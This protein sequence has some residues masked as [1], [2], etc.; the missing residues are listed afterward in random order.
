MKGDLT[1][2]PITKTM[3]LFA[4]PMILGNMLQQTYNVADTLIVG[5]FLGSDALAAVGS[6]YT[7]MSFLTSILL[8][9]CMGSGAVFSIAFGE[10]NEEKL[11]NSMYVSLILIGAVAIVLNVLVFVFLDP[12]MGLL[13]VPGRVYPM[14]KEYLWIIFFGIMATFLY[15]YFASLL[16]SLGNSVVPL[17]FL[18]VCAILNIFLDLAFVLWIKMGVGGAALATVISQYIS[19]IGI[20]IYTYV[21]MPQFRFEKKYCK[22]SRG[23]AKEITQFSFLTSLQQ[24]VM[25]FGILMVQG[26]INSFG[27]VVMAAFAAGVKIDSFAYMPVQDFGNAFSVFVAQNHGAKKEERI[28][29]GIKK[30]VGIAVVFCLIISAGVFLFAGPL[31]TIFVRA[32]ETEVIRIGAQYLRVEGAFYFGIGCLFLLYG[33]YRAVEKPGMS[34]VLTVISLGTR[35]I[36]AYT[37][38]SIEAIGVMGIWWSVPIGWILADLTGWIYYKLHKKELF[39]KS[40]M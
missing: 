33:F 31:M 2:G 29:L 28:R 11:K 20:A 27:P 4:L 1:K 35:V 6:S 37:L 23:I 24:S 39:Q 21:K 12:I 14:M 10:R 19:G 16:R 15:N 7:L 3:L 26:L 32:E 9:L 18:A 36:L 25:N 5:R 8:G 13:Q 38:S 17:I 22:L 30:A 40:R 34:V